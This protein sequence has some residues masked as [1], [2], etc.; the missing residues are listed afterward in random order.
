LVQ[1]AARHWIVASAKMSSGQAAA[2]PVQYSAT[3][4]GPCA[5]RQT[6]VLAWNALGGQL[7]AVPSQTAATSQAPVAA[8]QVVLG[9]CGVN[10]HWPAT[11]IGSCSQLPAAGVNRHWLSQDPQC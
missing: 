4:H 10:P 6:T 3:S 5:A 7:V 8:R 9:G 1:L 11:Q 2:S